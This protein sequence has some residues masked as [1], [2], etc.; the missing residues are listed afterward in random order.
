MYKETGCEQLN[1][2][3][4][5][6]LIE[7]LIKCHNLTSLEVV[8]LSGVGSTSIIEEILIVSNLP[9]KEVHLIGNAIGPEG[10][11]ALDR[12]GCF[13]NTFDLTISY[14]AIGSEGAITISNILK[15]R[16][17]NIL[18]LAGNLID[19]T[20]MV[21]LAKE[22]RNCPNLLHVSLNSNPI[23]L[24]CVTALGNGLINY[25]YLEQ[26]SIWG[27]DI[28]SDGIIA[29]ADAFFSW[30]GLTFLD[31]TDNK[32]CSKGMPALANGLSFL[33][34]LEQLY[35]SHKPD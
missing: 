33:C 16:N 32:L 1:S 20:G 15:K 35:L 27:G 11:L 10:A 34:N 5:E 3:S 17:I 8:D 19:S 13:K 24:D 6:P 7:A 23:W 29:L 28:T 31:L 25:F 14:N 21:A 9:L 18:V 26:L 30:R 12:E 4:A 22:L 2:S